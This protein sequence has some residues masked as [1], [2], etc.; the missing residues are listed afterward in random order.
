MPLAT[1]E[2]KVGDVVTG[3]GAIVIGLTLACSDCT[4]DHLFCTMKPAV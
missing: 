2:M 1:A 3:S 4:A